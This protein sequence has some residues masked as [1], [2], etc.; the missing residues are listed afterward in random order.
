MSRRYLHTD[1]KGRPIEESDDRSVVNSVSKTSFYRTQGT[2]SNTRN[3]TV[4]A[5]TNVTSPFAQAKTQVIHHEPLS[6]AKTRG[7][8]FD[9]GASMGSGLNATGNFSQNAIKASRTSIAGPKVTNNDLSV[10][11]PAVR[12]KSRLSALEQE[13]IAMANQ[14]RM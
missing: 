13:S 3:G 11:S 10:N 12:R 5:G 6:H 4:R 1:K 8:G 7:Q 14:E 9:S 2:M